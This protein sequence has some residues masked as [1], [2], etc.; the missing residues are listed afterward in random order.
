VHG[1]LRS[2]FGQLVR[3]E[4]HLLLLLLLRL[5]ELGDAGQLPVQ[6]CELLLKV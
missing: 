1:W 2:K 3:V 4:T 6:L 5:F